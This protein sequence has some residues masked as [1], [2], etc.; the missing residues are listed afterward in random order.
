MHMERPD[1]IDELEW[2]LLPLRR[3]SK[4]ISREFD[5]L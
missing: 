3:M 2:L 5:P 4:V 1:G